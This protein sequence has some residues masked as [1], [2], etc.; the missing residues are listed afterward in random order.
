MK[1]LQI[2]T[3][4]AVSMVFAGCASK[5]TAK[6]APINYANHVEHIDEEAASLGY[7]AKF[8]PKKQS[9]KNWGQPYKATIDNVE[10]EVKDGPV[11]EV[12]GGCDK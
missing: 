2:C 8:Y 7:P 4:I 3:V 9:N 5:T 6:P 10:V 1:I 11:V 12:C